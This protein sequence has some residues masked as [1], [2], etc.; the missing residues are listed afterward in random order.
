M[1]RDIVNRVPIETVTTEKYIVY[2]VEENS[3]DMTYM[4][5]L[6]RNTYEEAEQ[7]CKGDEL[8]IKVTTTYELMKGE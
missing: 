7:E 5:Y 4:H 1:N 8:I 6:K 2:D 3:K